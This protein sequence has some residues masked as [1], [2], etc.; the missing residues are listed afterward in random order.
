MAY[1]TVP[2][3]KLVVHAAIHPVVDALSYCT[4]LVNG[5]TISA[6]VKEM[7]SQYPERLEN[8]NSLFGVLEELERRLEPMGKQLDA[9]RLHFFFDIFGDIA[10]QKLSHYPN[11]ASAVF[12]PSAFSYEFTDLDAYRDTLKRYPME[13]IIFY[14]RVA[15]SVANEG[16]RTRECND[17]GAFYDYISDYP[18]SPEERYRILGAVRNFPKYVDE[19]TELLRPV[20]AA[21]QENVSLYQPLLNRFQTVYENA[22]L[23]ELVQQNA[24]FRI[25]DREAQRIDLYPCLFSVDERFTMSYRMSGDAPKQSHV[26]IGILFDAAEQYRK[27]DVSLKELAYYAKVLGDP[28]RLK[29]LT[30]AKNQELYV[31]DLT[32]KLN[33]SFTAVS[34]H[35]TKLIMAG[36]VSSERRGVCVY[37]R[38]NVDFFQWIVAQIADLM[39]S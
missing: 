24:N 25:F 26:E 1:S 17:F 23:E 18:A 4:R 34:H 36:L 22:D 12:M 6:T 37:Y 2:E 28:V 14:A 11:I 7:R 3:Q 10:D 5:K 39:H 33:L 35:M 38:T 32:E 19:L 9:E 21:I 13:E 16:W 29:I 30:L 8:I 20:V 31:Q 27:R 15:F